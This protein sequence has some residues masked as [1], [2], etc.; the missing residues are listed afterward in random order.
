MRGKR[1]LK[2][3]K[4]VHVVRNTKPQVC[5]LTLKGAKASGF[6]EAVY[7]LHKPKEKTMSIESLTIGEAREIANLFG[8]NP[9]SRVGSDAATNKPT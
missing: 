3:R 7:F 2:I 6:I 8:F 5:A 4:G 9:R 1:S